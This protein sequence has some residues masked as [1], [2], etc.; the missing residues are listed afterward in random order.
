MV[1]YLPASR[2]LLQTA[3]VSAIGYVIVRCLDSAKNQFFPVYANG[4]ECAEK[5]GLKKA[6]R[7]AA[8]ALNTPLSQLPTMTIGNIFHST[9]LTSAHLEEITTFCQNHPP[10]LSKLVSDFLSGIS[11]VFGLLG[12][13]SLGGWAIRQIN[14]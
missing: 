1:S 10:F 5:E 3:G 4:L 6:K 7:I 8:C 13:V 9:C 12:I 2:A 11:T 14:L